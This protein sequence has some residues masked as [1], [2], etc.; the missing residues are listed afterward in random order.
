MSGVT[1][2]PCP[3]EGE[4]VNLVRSKSVDASGCKGGAV[5][6]I[7]FQP[8]GGHLPPTL[9][10]STS[11]RFRASPRILFCTTL[12]KPGEG[13]GDFSMP[14][15]FMVRHG[16]AGVK[17]LVQFTQMQPNRSFEL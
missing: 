12:S 15:F 4:R 10:I 9:A 5:G 8:P 6:T 1:P 7:G 16:L 13:S 11:L 3:C 14:G 2:A 17:L